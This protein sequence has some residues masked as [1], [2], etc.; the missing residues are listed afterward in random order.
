MLILSYHLGLNG[1][2]PLPCPRHPLHHRIIHFTRRHTLFRPQGDKCYIGS[3]ADF[4]TLPNV[5]FWEGSTVPRIV[6]PSPKGW[7]DMLWV[8]MAAA[9]ILLLAFAA[10]SV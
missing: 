8:L 2:S 7:Q 1:S 10:L 6:E 5:G 9:G 4:V 3:R